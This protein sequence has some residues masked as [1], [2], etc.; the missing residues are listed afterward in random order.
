MD[1]VRANLD[2]VHKLPRKQAFLVEDA[3]AV[4]TEGSY[5]SNYPKE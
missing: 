3:E 5:H 1:E 2:G 4:D